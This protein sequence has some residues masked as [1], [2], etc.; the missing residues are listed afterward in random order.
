MSYSFYLIPDVIQ[1]ASWSQ[2]CSFGIDSLR[3]S[4]KPWISVS[5]TRACST[6]L[7]C[8]PRWF[9][10]MAVPWKNWG[11]NSCYFQPGSFWRTRAHWEGK[12]TTA[13]CMRTTPACTI[14]CSETFAVVRRSSEFVEVRFAS[15]NQFLPSDK[16]A[17]TWKDLLLHSHLSVW[18]CKSIVFSS[19]LYFVDF[20]SF[21]PK[22]RTKIASTFFPIGCLDFP[23]VSMAKCVASKALMAL[24]LLRMLV[25]FASS[26]VDK[27]AT[28]LRSVD[29]DN[30]V[31]QNPNR[32]GWTSRR[33]VGW[34]VGW[35]FC[36]D[37]RS[38]F[39]E[40]SCSQ[41]NEFEDELYNIRKIEMK[42]Q[43]CFKW[44]KAFEATY[45]QAHR[46]LC[47]IYTMCVCVCH[48][49]DWISMTT[50]LQSDTLRKSAQN[51]NLMWIK[52][53]LT[54]VQQNMRS[55][56]L[57]F[58][59]FVCPCLERS[60]WRLLENSVSSSWEQKPFSYTF[61]HQTWNHQYRVRN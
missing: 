51:S 25:V 55:F 60:A 53:Q 57:V 6:S 26:K 8:A 33:L 11:G 52:K 44:M 37:E 13:K 48:S 41:K 56:P 12:P 40:N 31:G 49:C 5:A 9:C 30:H 36:C 42:R 4:N 50:S 2:S 22:H 1:I 23:R 18:L 59:V 15:S 61:P 58:S 3:Q 7:S 29:S 38:S 34:L 17:S 20:S 10:V 54:T 43:T 27:S 19:T 45:I 35:S 32:L 14:F 39:F 46:E 21:Q 24:E 28:R 16:D 47:S